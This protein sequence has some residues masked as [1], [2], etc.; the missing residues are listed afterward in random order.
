MMTQPIRPPSAASRSMSTSTGGS[1]LADVLERVLDK[2]IV[3][4]GDISVSVG[5]TELLSIRIRLLVASVDKAKEMGINWWETDPYLSTQAR[6]LT[7]SNQLLLEQVKR[8]DEEVR[9]LKALS[10]SQQPIAEPTK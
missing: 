9:S 5:S 3:I 1:T 7:E 2:G 10:A 4:A 6:T 8:L